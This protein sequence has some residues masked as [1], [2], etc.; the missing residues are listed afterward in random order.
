MYDT[1]ELQ[2]EARYKQWWLEMYEVDDDN[3]GHESYAVWWLSFI[4]IINTFVLI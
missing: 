4:I 3:E 2:W 1:N